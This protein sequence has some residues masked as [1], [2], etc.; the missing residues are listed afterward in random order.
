MKNMEAVPRS[1]YN[2]AT[3]TKNTTT[4]STY[5]HGYTYT[6][7]AC[8]LGFFLSSTPYMNTL[9]FRLWP[10]RSMYMCTSRS[11]RC[12]CWLK[13]MAYKVSNVMVFLCVCVC[14]TCMKILRVYTVGCSDLTGVFHCRLRSTPANAHRLLPN[15][16]PAPR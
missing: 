6:Y 15:T 13:H 16:T 2:R 12:I 7:R 4:Q 11:F 3:T 5:K 9:Y 10:C 1:C 14:C 8:G